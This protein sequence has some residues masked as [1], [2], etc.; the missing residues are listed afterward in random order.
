MLSSIENQGVLP[1][2]YHNIISEENYRRMC[3]LDYKNGYS[4]EKYEF[5]S[6]FTKFFLIKAESNCKF[7]YYR[8][9]GNPETDYI[10]HDEVIIYYKFENWKWVVD[11]LYFYP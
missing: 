4:D 7:T 3:I 11:D 6:A 5:D 10:V 1:E 8:N 9:K 2:K